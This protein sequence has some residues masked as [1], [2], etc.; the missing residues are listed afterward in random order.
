M[1]EPLERLLEPHPVESVPPGGSFHD[2]VDVAPAGRLRTSHGA[3]HAQTSDVVVSGQFEDT[4][5]V[6]PQNLWDS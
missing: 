1:Q 6:R 2:Q 4:I 5:S 3:E